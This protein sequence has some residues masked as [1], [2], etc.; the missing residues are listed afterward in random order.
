MGLFEKI[1][2]RPQTT[3][4][5]T[6][7]AQP[8]Y[9]AL[10]AYQPVFTTSNGA[11]YEDALIRSTIHAAAKHCSKLRVEFTGH[12]AA[13]LSRRLQ[14]P[15]A[16]QTWSQFLYRAR[17]I[18]D[19]DNTCVIVPGFDRFG[20]VDCLYT[21]VP[22]SCTI[23]G[24]SQNPMVALRFPTGGFVQLPVWQVG[25]LT[26]YQYSD[27]FFGGDNRA[28]NQT[29][30]LISIQNQGILEAIKSSATYRFMAVMGNFTDPEDLAKKRKEFDEQNFSGQG[31]GLLLFPNIF[32]NPQQIKP[33]HFVIDA[34]QMKIIKDNVFDYFGSNE[35]V[36]QNKCY[37]DKWN[38][39]YEGEIEPWSIQLSEVLTCMLVLSGELTGD[40]AVMATSNRLQYLSN[41]EKLNVSTQ[42]VDRGILNIDEAR[43]IWN[44]PPLPDGKGKIYRIRGEYKDAEGPNG[45]VNNPNALPQPQEDGDNAE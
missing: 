39:Y 11:I 9:Q 10:T 3:A 18:L 34:D 40:G 6:G 17:T 23:V 32:G 25:I 4:Q 14:R 15:N 28:L 1:F 24:D 27:D 35:D 20:R 16:F 7:P 13:G 12:G 43:E 29:L 38:A 19:V 26:K 22:S 44:L 21:V 37:G 5:P 36:L 8:I 45:T 2:G 41:S 31:G 30:N 42:L 33:D